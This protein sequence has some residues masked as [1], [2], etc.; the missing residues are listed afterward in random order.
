MYR[1]SILKYIFFIVIM[2]LCRASTASACSLA[3]HDWQLKFFYKIPINAPF[4]PLSEIAVIQKQFNRAVTDRLFWAVKP[5]VLTP[6]NDFIIS[7]IDGWV[8][9]AKW[10]IVPNNK[11]VIKLARSFSK[12]ENKPL[13][14]G[15]DNNYLKIAVFLDANSNNNC[16]QIVLAQDSRIRCIFQDPNKPWA[17]E[18]SMESWF[19]LIFY[20]LPIPGYI[21]SFSTYPID[22]NRAAL[23]EDHPLVETL[24]SKKM[25]MRR[26]DLV[27]DPYSFDFPDL[28]E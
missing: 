7:F 1:N 16:C 28:P 23:Y 25:L 6:F 13:I 9:K 2:L 10:I 18:Y 27:I 12:D 15:S 21:L 11:S 8:S 17:Q 26:P 19:S 24:L 22:G 14:V 4:I 20:R 5:G 3:L